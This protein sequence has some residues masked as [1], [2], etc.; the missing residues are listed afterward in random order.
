MATYRAALSYRTRNAVVGGV[1][2]RIKMLHE[3]DECDCSNGAHE[4]TYDG[5]R[6]YVIPE[7]FHHLA[8]LYLLRKRGHSGCM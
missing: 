1:R 7:C 4:A 6:D 3:L 8:L 5:A 2:L